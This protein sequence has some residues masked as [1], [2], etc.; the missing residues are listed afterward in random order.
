M[1][2]SNIASLA[3]HQQDANMQSL[4]T[5]NNSS[6]ESINIDY[7]LAMYFYYFL[8]GKTN[9]LPSYSFVDQIIEQNYNGIISRGYGLIVS[10]SLDDDSYFSITF[11]EPINESVSRIEKISGKQHKSYIDD[12]KNEA[13]YEV[14]QDLPLFDEK[15]VLS[16]QKY[17]V[18][19]YLKKNKSNYKRY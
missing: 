7:K 17:I 12:T 16:I 8:K 6:Y 11:E 15:R 14:P 18:D 10:M 13:Q 2:N 4:F 19:Y 5:L 9:N 3:K 1:K